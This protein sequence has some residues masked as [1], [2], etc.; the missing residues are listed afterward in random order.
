MKFERAADMPAGRPPTAGSGQLHDFRGIEH[1]D[2]LLHQ[3][4]R[5]GPMRPGAKQGGRSARDGRV[6]V[7]GQRDQVA[8]LGRSRRGKRKREGVEPAATADAQA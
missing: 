3:P 4:P 6:E 8:H 7:A 2:E 5:P 1:A